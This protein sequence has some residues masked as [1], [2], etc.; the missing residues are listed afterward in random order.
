MRA[1]AV[2]TTGHDPRRLYERGAT[3]RLDPAGV[4]MLTGTGGRPLDF[5]VDVSADRILWTFQADRRTKATRR[6]EFVADCYFEGEDPF[7]ALAS[8]L[9]RL[10]ETDEWSIPVHDRSRLDLRG[11]SQDPSREPEARADGEIYDIPE[12]LAAADRQESG[13]VRLSVEGYDDAVRTVTTLYQAGGEFTVGVASASDGSLD[14]PEQVDVLLAV[15]D[16]DSQSLKEAGNRR[17][18][19]GGRAAFKGS[20]TDDRGVRE[21]EDKADIGAND[22][23]ERPVTAD[24]RGAVD[25]E[26]INVRTRVAAVALTVVFGF[27]AYGLLSTRLVHPISSVGAF[28]GTLGGIAGVPLLLDTLT[29]RSVTG[30]LRSVRRTLADGTGNGPAAVAAGGVLGFLFPT[31]LRVSGAVLF[32]SQWVFGPV[33]SL[34]F[35]VPSAML[36]V[37]V[38]VAAVVVART[39]VS[40]A[41][42]IGG[43]DPDRTRDLVVGA[44]DTFDD[45]RDTALDS[46]RTRDIV[47]GV[48]VYATAL[49]V[50][51]GLSRSLWFVVLPTM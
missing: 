1:L 3:D 27:S 21:D 10:H 13:P 9:R 33:S 14:G 49:S 16:D 23:S 40:G 12:Q 25:V 7:E 28:G 32:G 31:V 37:G 24:D 51:T 11:L 44:D 8:E 5:V 4:G 47:A 30:Y 2:Y 39:V 29:D 6:G 22:D 26:S 17:E 18:D 45:I 38:C 48:A 35:S 36:Y 50:A 19:P 43:L 42:S 20:A 41:G 15:V 34:L 46:D